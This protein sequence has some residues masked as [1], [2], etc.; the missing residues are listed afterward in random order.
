M[1]AG[2]TDIPDPADIQD[3]DIIIAVMG[4]TGCG[5]TTFVNHFADSPLMIGHGLESCTQDVQIVPCTLEGGRKIYLVDTPGFDDSYRSDSDILRELADWLNSAHKSNI[6]LTGLILLHRIL[7]VRVGGTGVRNIRMFKRLCGDDSLGSVV[8][9]TTMWDFIRDGSIGDSREDELKTQEA[10]WKPLIQQ[11]SKV[12]RQNDEQRSATKIIEYL[13]DRKKPVTLDIQ[14]EMVD[15]NLTLAQTGA[16]TE[17]ATD[18]EKQKLYYEK[19]LRDLETQLQEAIAKNQQDRKEDLEADKREFEAKVLRYQ[20]E[21]IRL[22]ADTNQ[23]HEEIRRRYETDLA[24]MTKQIE[25][26][27]Q[28]GEL[29]VEKLRETHAH[30]L[31]QQKLL[32]H[33]KY[34]QKYVEALSGRCSVM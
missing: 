27:R 2:F 22:Q 11:G 32:L 31:E 1:N 34:K 8:L 15:Q 18:V 20:E 5:K 3:D 29:E 33:A 17:V 6:K 14:R 30:R 23:L 13:M 9:A 25:L 12:F 4:I 28:A 10:L 7:D 26:A 16:G 24:D 21:N 19:R